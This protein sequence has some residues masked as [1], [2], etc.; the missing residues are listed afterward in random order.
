MLGGWDFGDTIR[1]K[2]GAIPND[3]REV[4]TSVLIEA[5]QPFA[6]TLKICLTGG[7][8][9]AD[10]TITK[11]G[12][13]LTFLEDTLGFSGYDG[14]KHALIPLYEHLGVPQ[15]ELPGY[16]EFLARAIDPADGD[17]AFFKML[18][19]PLLNLYERVAADP[20]NEFLQLL[21]N[22]IYFFAAEDADGGNN[23]S[24]CM[25]R[26]LRPVNAALDMVTP[27][28]PVKE[29]FALLGIPYP[30]RFDAAGNEYELRLPVTDSAN[31]ILVDLLQSFI[32]QF[33]DKV[34]LNITLALSELTDLITGNLSIYESKNGQEDAVRLDAAMPDL[35]TNL[36]RKLIVLIFS[37]ENY[38]ELRSFIEKRLPDNRR[39]T[40]LWFLD[41]QEK[42]FRKKLN[43][44]DGDDRVLGDLYLRF[45]TKGFNAGWMV[46]VREW[47]GG[48]LAKLFGAMLGSRFSWIN[49]IA[50]WILDWWGADYFNMDGGL[51]PKGRWGYFESVVEHWK[52]TYPTISGFIEWWWRL[53]KPLWFAVLGW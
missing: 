1:A 8:T 50:R 43:K 40:V 10:G 15:D 32:G 51:L 23:F 26:P 41:Q 38:A 19:D 12:G 9:E 27:M 35:L 47:F 34:G 14:Y 17:A 18:I 6:A 3:D 53:F 46:T 13:N 30:V 36:L 7:R 22:M 4:F 29:A 42:C 37:E 49:S 5:L 28:L 45:C 21:P 39:K 11:A 20:L 24:Q 44:S 31:G 33:S 16:S 52:K 25:N 2:A 48:L